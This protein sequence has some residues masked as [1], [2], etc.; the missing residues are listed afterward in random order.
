MPVERKTG[1]LLLATLSRK[2][3]LVKLH[4]LILIDLMPIFIRIF[5][6]SKSKGVHKKSILIFFTKRL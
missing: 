4:E 5:K 6:L 1:N 2:G 3:I